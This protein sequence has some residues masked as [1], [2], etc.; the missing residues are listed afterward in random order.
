MY[1]PTMPIRK[2]ILGNSKVTRRYQ[3]TLPKGIRE[4]L[5]FNIE[6]LVVF[7]LS[8]EGKLVVKKIEL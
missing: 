4:E 7:T 8:R 1:S 5:N 3:I 6:D 2:E